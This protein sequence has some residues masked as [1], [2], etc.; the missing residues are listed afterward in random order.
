MLYNKGRY[1]EINRYISSFNWEQTFSNLDLNSSAYALYDALYF[2]VLKYVPK[3]TFIK[4]SFPTWVSKHMKDLIFQKKRAHADYKSSGS[5]VHYREFSILRARC[6]FEAKRCFRSFV[7]NAEKSFNDEPKSFWDFVRKHRSPNPIPKTAFYNNTAG[8]DEQH[9]ANLFSSFFNS[10][11]TPKRSNCDLS[12][13]NILEYDLPSNS[14]FSVDDVFDGLTS[15]R[16][17]KSIW[18]D[19]LSGVFLFN[20]RHSITFP[21]WLL[22]RRSLDDGFFPDIWKLCTITPVLKSGDASLVTNYR[23]I[24]ILSHIAKLFESLVLNNIQPSVNRLLMEEQHGFRSGC[25]TTTRNAVFFN[26]IFEAVKAHS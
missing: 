14:F 25:S 21:L 12:N 20:V 16:N 24:S 9:S 18:P 5:L 19:G 6:K 11:Y 15:L 10:V 13:I 4:S 1:K 8:H 2:T 7:S 17:N 23:P 26:Y 3:S 22:F